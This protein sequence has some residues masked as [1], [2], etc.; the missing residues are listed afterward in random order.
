MVDEE[1]NKHSE[2]KEMPEHKEEIKKEEHKTEKTHEET[3]KHSEHKEK[4]ESKPSNK[5]KEEHVHKKTAHK[6][7][8]KTDNKT[9]DWLIITLSSILV[10]AIV[11]ALYFVFIKVNPEETQDSV[12]AIVNGQPIYESQIQTRMKLIQTLSD[13]TIDFN[14]TKDMMIDEALLYQEAKK[15]G[16]DTTPEE[17]NQ[18]ISG[19]IAQND[20]DPATFEQELNS[21]GIKLED[22]RNLYEKTL[23]VN[24][25]IN[26]TVVSA[27]LVSTQEEKEFYDN[28]TENLQLPARV[29]VRHILIANNSTNNVTAEEV[30]AMINENKSNFCDLVKEYSDD[31]E[32]VSYCG[33]FNFSRQDPIVEE[34]IN[35]SFDMKPGEVRIVETIFGKHIIYKIADI[36]AGTPDF[37]EIQPQIAD[38]LKQQKISE[39]YQEL[40]QTLRDDAIIEKY[41][42]QTA[43]VLNESLSGNVIKTPTKE[44]VPTEKS[45]KLELAECLTEKGA[46]L[47]KVYWCPHCEDQIKEF[48]D[49]A[50][51]L[52]IIECDPEGENPQVEECQAAGIKA[53]P[54]WIINGT[55]YEGGQPL[56]KLAEYSG[57]T[58]Q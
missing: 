6:Q 49:A 5:N 21:A 56:E 10:V 47:Y 11:I 39:M 45:T 40:I 50:S 32:S 19:I 37:E 17:I 33:E 30:K 8:K 43:P 2:N 46:K 53:L 14:T 26:K 29:Q 9:P 18:Y 52:D 55:K 12:A 36:P 54:T 27:A 3:K 38:Y 7:E 16:Y 42:N 1:K 20:L 57:C 48:G 13:P 4:A 22:L 15:E 35:A 24:K 44:I 25:L 31:T 51:K 41:T 34:F 28:N 58:Y 23:T